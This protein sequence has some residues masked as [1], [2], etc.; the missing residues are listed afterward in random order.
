MPCCFCYHFPSTA[1]Q[2]S[3]LPSFFSSLESFSSI[4]NFFLLTVFLSAHFFSPLIYP[5]LLLLPL[6][7][8][9]VPL[10]PLNNTFKKKK[11][12]IFSIFRFCFLFLYNILSSLLTGLECIKHPHSTSDIVSLIMNACDGETDTKKDRQVL[13]LRRS[14]SKSAKT[15]TKN[16]V[17]VK[18]R[19]ANRH[20][21][22][23]KTSLF[24]CSPELDNVK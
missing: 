10:I 14:N 13:V 12:I 2:P 24:S 22:K 6:F 21:N 11:K 19:G 17:V 18:G 7:H 15:T 4:I 16:N 3:F 8:L 5:L 9:S 1:F 23:H 20:S